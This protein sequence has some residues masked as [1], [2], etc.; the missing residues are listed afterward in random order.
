MLHPMRVIVSVAMTLDGFIDDRSAER[1][2]LSHPDDMRDVRAL[3]AQCDA[4]LVGAGTVRSDNPS[5]RVESG[6]PP[7]RVTVTRSGRLD[8]SARFFDGSARTI[9]LAAPSARMQL[10]AHV[11]VLPLRDETPSGILHALAAAG[12]GSLFVEG[13]TQMLTAFLASGTFDRLRVAVAPFFAGDAGGARAVD[14]ARFAD[15][16]AHRLQLMS[17]KSVGDMAVLDYER[18]R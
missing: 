10:P 18:A 2:V 12:I 16:A 7:A 1:L 3:R 4:V 11:E 9:V 17:T 14:P 6:T 5:L 15:D 13:G 8:P